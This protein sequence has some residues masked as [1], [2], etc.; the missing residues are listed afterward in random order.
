MMTLS[1]PLEAVPVSRKGK[2]ETENR[3]GKT[4]QRSSNKKTRKSEPQKSAPKTSREAKRQQQQAQ[5][6]VNA[7]AKKIQLNDKELAGAVRE[8]ESLEAD[9]HTS[10]AE[11]AKLS[12][13]IGI[14]NGRIGALEQQITD[15]KTQLAS[16]RSL[17]WV[18]IKQMRL[19]QGTSSALAFIFSSSSFNQ[20]MR[21]WRYLRQ[22]AA[23][24]RN[25]SAAITA[26][27]ALLEKQEQELALARQQKNEALNRQQAVTNNLAAQRSRK[28]QVVGQLQANGQALNAYIARK[29]QE[30]NALGAQAASLIAV[31]EA[32]EAKRKAQAEAA[33]KRKAEADAKAK[34]AKPK[35]AAG[36][37]QSPSPA[38]KKED[39]RKY[40]DARRR[41]PRKQPPTQTSQ[42]DA[43][44]TPTPTQAA[45][46]AAQSGFASSRGAL[47]RPVPGAFRIINGYG[48]QT[49]GGMKTVVYDNTGIDV[50][51]S[52]G[53]HATAVY[54]GTVAAIYQATGFSNV[55]LIKHG[56][57][58]TVYA[59]LSSVSVYSGQT[60]KQ[61]TV[62]GTVAQDPDNAS[63]GLFHF[64]V[65]KQRT[66]LN[67]S[68]WIR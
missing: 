43:T 7:T 10:E 24:R 48:R 8:V 36:K 1:P 30:V 68:D 12:A 38:R 46:P 53:A 47:P 25:Q 55:V 41:K 13:N 57:Y 56:E 17:Y 23:W 2:P 42:S 50:E 11:A 64:E 5:R 63:H 45:K 28:Q 22:F 44:P 39:D 35:P 49:K 61:G 14:L 60:V 15:G 59:N 18:A 40:A 31:E 34:A 4:T 62:I 20:A 37:Q 32:A 51:V 9:I 65:W 16:M 58:Y 67:P 6:E 66:R 52:R 54:A 27:V 3:K 33:A 26:R 21:R 29:Q 19:R